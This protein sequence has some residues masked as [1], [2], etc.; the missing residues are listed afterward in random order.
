MGDREEF[1]MRPILCVRDVPASTRYFCEKLGFDRSWAFPDDSPIIA[2]VGRNGLDLILDS[3]SSIP[4]AATPSVL[5]MSLHD[6]AS[7]G[8]LYRDFSSRGALTQGPPSAV[9]WQEGVFQLEVHD[10]DGNVLLF[11]GD[12]PD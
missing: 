1:Y 12:E 9:S 5:S 3:E 10:L 7:L 4:R 11:W 6:P 2:Q 8:A